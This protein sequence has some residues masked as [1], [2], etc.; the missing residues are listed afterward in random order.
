MDNITSISPEVLF[1][2]GIMAIVLLTVKSNKTVIPFLITGCFVTE[3]QRIVV[4][5]FDFTMLRILITVGLVRIVLKR[6]WVSLKLNSID[7]TFIIYVVMNT[8]IYTFRSFE[9]SAFENRLGFVI[10]ALG[11]YFFFRIQIKNVDDLKIV[12]ITLAYI[13]LIMSLFMLFENR[14]GRNFFSLFGG[15][16][17]FTQIR[18][19]RLRC[20]G[21]FIHP[22]MAGAFAA[23]QIPLMLILIRDGRKRK[24]IGFI[25]LF[26]STIIAIT[27]ATSGALLSILAVIIGFFMWSFHSNMKAIRGL[28]IF[29]LIILHFVMKAPVWALVGRVSVVGGSTGYHRFILIDSGIR[30]FKDWW[31]MGLESTEYWGYGLW[32]ITNQ[33]VAEGVEGG[34]V[35]LILFISVIVLCFKYIGLSIVKYEGDK[36][37]QKFFWSLGVALFSHLVA[38]I[39]MH[40]FAGQSY[41]GWFLLLSSISTVTHL[42]KFNSN[43]EYEDKTIINNIVGV[44]I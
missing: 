36:I 34:L 21:A 33:Y 28:V 30:H 8:I 3:Y 14:T 40:Y 1:L 18:E 20:Q 10:N 15:V 35:S 19:G 39:G 24:T 22:L 38:F 23:T 2:T 13:S 7:K 9:F 11:M 42:E 6:E 31:L 41:I 27:S 44:G 17:E 43:D 29:S 32:D 12:I 25:G 26:T 4:A 5:G 16:P 37:K